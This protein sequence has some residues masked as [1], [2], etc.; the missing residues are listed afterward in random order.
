[1]LHKKVFDLAKNYYRRT[2][3]IMHIYK[4][5]DHISKHF[6]Y[7]ELTRSQTATR[8]GIDNTPTPEQIQNLIN[9]SVNILEPIRKHYLSPV[10]ITSGFRNQELNTKIGGSLTSQHQKGEAADIVISGITVT[11]G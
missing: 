3:K 10:F 9:L 4:N 6:S 1:M 7:G 5:N 8:C 2:G 11:D